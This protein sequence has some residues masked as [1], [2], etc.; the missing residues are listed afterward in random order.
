[1]NKTMRTALLVLYRALFTCLVLGTIAFIFHN[2]L[3][4]GAESSSRST[5]VAA[6]INGC[7]SRLG[8]SPLSEHAVRKLAHYAEFLLL[9]FL[10]TLCLRVYTR[11]YLRYLC[12]PLLLG[13]LV[14]NLDETIQLSSVGRT[15]SVADVWI[16]FGGVFSGVLAALAALLFFTAVLR[17]MGFGRKRK[18]DA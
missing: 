17:L 11:R 2:S 7:L 14:A 16:D 3:E 10:L 15:S 13:L 12:W 8:L 18:P 6:L 1:M 5:E 9:G 4:N